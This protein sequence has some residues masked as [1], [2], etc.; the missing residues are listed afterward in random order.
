[1]I[2]CPVLLPE[3]VLLALRQICNTNPNDDHGQNPKT[4]F[5]HR[6][7]NILSWRGPGEKTSFC[8]TNPNR[9][10]QHMWWHGFVKKPGVETKQNEAK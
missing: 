9:E 10:L 5:F 4:S 8:E 3:R 2:L 1:M 6:E 7:M